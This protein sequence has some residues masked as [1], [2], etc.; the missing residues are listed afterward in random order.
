M[1]DFTPKKGMVH[2]NNALDNVEGFLPND[3]PISAF[4]NITGNKL[5]VNIQDGT[6]PKNGINGIQ[7]T[8]L[9]RY[10]NE[11]Y[12]SLNGAHPCKENLN[13][14]KFL[15]LALKEQHYRTLDREARG[16]EGKDKD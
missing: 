11:V 12:K 15:E 8:D 13:T 16:V 5:S 14:I 10:V 6:I 7:I 2:L 3:T 9:L 4:I 1:E